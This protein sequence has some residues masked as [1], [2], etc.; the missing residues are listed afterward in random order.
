MVM[1]E[2]YNF[3]DEPVYKHNFMNV[4]YEAVDYDMQLGMPGLHTV[5]SKVEYI[6]RKPIIPPDIFMKHISTDFWSIKDNLN[7]ARV[8]GER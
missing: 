7:K 1:K 2:I 3:I 8:A 6:E 4:S 5:K